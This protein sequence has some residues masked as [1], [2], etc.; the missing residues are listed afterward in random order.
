VLAVDNIPIAPAD[1]N[2][3][4]LSQIGEFVPRNKIK[5]PG[6]VGL[7]IKD[8]HENV[9]EVTE[10]RNETRTVE[11]MGIKGLGFEWRSSVRGGPGFYGNYRVVKTEAKQFE[12]RTVTVTRPDGVASKLLT[13]N[14]RDEFDE[15]L[16]D[17]MPKP[18][19]QSGGHSDGHD[20]HHEFIAPERFRLRESE[21]LNFTEFG[22]VTPTANN[23]GKDIIPTPIADNEAVSVA[24]IEEQRQRLG[25]DSLNGLTWRDANGREKRVVF[26]GIDT[27]SQNSPNDKYSELPRDLQAVVTD[28]IEGRESAYYTAPENQRGL[29]TVRVANTDVTPEHKSLKKLPL[30]HFIQRFRKKSN[31]KI[32]PGQDPGGKKFI[33]YRTMSLDELQAHFDEIAKARAEN[34]AASKATAPKW[35][36]PVTEPGPEQLRLDLLRQ[37]ELK[38]L[39]RARLA[40]TIGRFA[41]APAVYTKPKRDKL[42]DPGVRRDEAMGLLLGP[43]YVDPTNPKSVALWESDIQHMLTAPEGIRKRYE[44]ECLKKMINDIGSTA[45][46]EAADSLLKQYRTVMSRSGMTVAGTNT[47]I[48]WAY[49]QLGRRYAEAKRFPKETA[50]DR[51]DKLTPGSPI[52]GNLKAETVRREL[53]DVEVGARF[54]QQARTRVDMQVMD[55]RSG[56]LVTVP[57]YKIDI[58]FLKALPISIQGTLR[59]HM[60]RM[61]SDPLKT[62]D[63]LEMGRLLDGYWD[64]K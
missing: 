11:T 31:A 34:P 4:V 6:L 9:Y 38:T 51:L 57:T 52:G 42:T 64:E 27:E 33:S 2:K 53:I 63:Y 56:K 61:P 24:I 50:E 36:L 58:N 44:A 28:G 18:H 59:E 55:Q 39:K 23:G 40:S 26:D 21:P 32:I 3:S 15:F 62:L 22:W 10:C 14:S 30:R 43:E 17:N 13:F 29:R 35:E 25:L 8:E 12:R 19:A 16:T 20:A 54:A 7:R 49:A 1:P 45:A 60:N 5:D 37:E 48:S 41:T 47:S 46:S